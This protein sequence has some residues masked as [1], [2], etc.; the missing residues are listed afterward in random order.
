MAVPDSGGGVQAVED[1]AVG[2]GREADAGE[3]VGDLA[4]RMAVRRENS[5]YRRDSCHGVSIR[6]AV[7]LREAMTTERVTVA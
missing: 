2:S 6:T 1:G 5:A 7:A 3:R 4:L